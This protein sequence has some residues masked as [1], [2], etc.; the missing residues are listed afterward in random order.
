MIGVMRGTKQEIHRAT[1]D[2]ADVPVT[3]DADRGRIEIDVN[4]AVGYISMRL[5]DGVLALLHTETP[6][7]L[8]GKGAGNALARAALDHA[9]TAGLTVEPFCPFVS[10]YI[11]R[12]PEYADL[13]S[14]TFRQS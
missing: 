12:H 5:Q 4:G 14:P 6:P 11:Q 7:S 3:L 9:R 1:I 8:R 2:G 10:A 13:I